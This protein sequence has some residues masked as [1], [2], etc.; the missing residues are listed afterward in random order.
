LIETTSTLWLLRATNLFEAMVVPLTYLAG[1]ILVWGCWFL[2]RLSVHLPLW[3][4]HAVLIVLVN[5]SLLS[6]FLVIGETYLPLCKNVSW[7]VSRQTT[8]GRTV[9]E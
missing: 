9:A 2:V 5:V 8:D 6:F 3:G 7:S 1:L 4:R